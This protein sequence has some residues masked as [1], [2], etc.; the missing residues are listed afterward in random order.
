MKRVSLILAFLCCSISILANT[1]EALE[2]QLVSAKSHKKQVQELVETDIKE[3]AQ[4]TE[5]IA[6]LESELMCLNDIE[7]SQQISENRLQ[8]RK[9]ILY[10]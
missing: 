8:R 2:T 1:K 6:R 7:Y 3:I 4:T 5:K 10:R 9:G